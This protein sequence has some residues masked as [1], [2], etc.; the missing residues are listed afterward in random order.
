MSAGRVI[1]LILLVFV[2]GMI[3]AGVK[4]VGLYRKAFA[5]NIVVT[6]SDKAFFYVSTGAGY[7]EVFE[8]LFEKDYLKNPKTFDWTA[9]RKNYPNHVKPG[10]YMIKNRMSNNDLVNM[11]RSGKQVPVMVTFNNIN[12]ID[13][14][15]SRISEQLEL[16]SEDLIAVLTEDSVVESYGF[17]KYTIPA[18]FIPNSYEFYWNTSVDGF[19][20]RM[21]KEYDQFWTRGRL[22]KAK[23][24][25]M[26]PEEVITL[27]SIVN[28]EV[29]FDDE[30]RR[31]AGLY[32]NRIEKGI[33][34]QADPTLIFA[35]DDFSI[36]RVLNKHK[37]LDSPY[38]T[39][40]NYGLPPGPICIPDIISIDA[41]LNYEKHDYIYMCAKPDFSGYHNFAKTLK[42]H[43]RNAEAYRKE[44][45][46]RR[47]YN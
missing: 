39:Y 6:N 29:M 5:P 28:K 18:M 14:L 8:R 23:K 10:R 12:T 46:K 47:I 34:L 4:G 2:V 33:R 40:K 44:L 27:A 1:K 38:N 20:K 21:E 42:A 26:T 41:V 31:V 24:L 11:L 19:L 30:K 9:K 32:L 37:K 36:R 7:D 13:E 43:N 22:S 25:G 3:V 15:S 17:S 45:N 35:M 16:K